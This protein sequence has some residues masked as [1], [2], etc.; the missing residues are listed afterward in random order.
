MYHM[1]QPD[2]ESNMRSSVLADEAANQKTSCDPT[3]SPLEP[4]CLADV[5]AMNHSYQAWHTLGFNTFSALSVGACAFTV[6][7]ING[8]VSLLS[9]NSVFSN[10]SL[11]S[12]FSILSTNSAFAIG[13]VDKRFAICFNQ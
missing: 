11:N 2:M 13:C 3:C 7:T 5:N 8:I 9:C 6:L 12:A 10:L 1:S 4:S